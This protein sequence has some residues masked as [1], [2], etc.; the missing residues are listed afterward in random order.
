MKKLLKGLLTLFIIALVI[1]LGL[2][3]L[4][5][6]HGLDFPASGILAKIKN[7]WEDMTKSADDFLTE[8]GIKGDTAELLEKGAELLKAT[9][10]PNGTADTEGGEEPETESS[11]EADAD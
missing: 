9:P 1:L 10:D 8:S 2:S 11:P 5:K 3:Y 6:E 4:E 7:G